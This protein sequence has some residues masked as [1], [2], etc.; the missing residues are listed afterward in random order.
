M[1]S[2]LCFPSGSSGGVGVG[3]CFSYETLKCPGDK[4]SHATYSALLFF[5]LKMIFTLFFGT[6]TCQD[7]V[8]AELL[9]RLSL[10]D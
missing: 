4:C 5:P 9:E 7:F 8:V 1:Y 10:W 3:H 6:D 2:S